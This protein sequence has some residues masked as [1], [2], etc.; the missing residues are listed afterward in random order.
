MKLGQ[1]RIEVPCMVEIEQTP[2]SLHAHAIPEGIAIRPGDTVIV[3]GAPTRVPFGARVRVAC[4]ATVYRAG[5]I[6]RA[7]THIV[8]PFQLTELYE[9]GFQPKESS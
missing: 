1:R 4:R 9:V 8:A 6:A 3:H 2:A 5:P 7:W